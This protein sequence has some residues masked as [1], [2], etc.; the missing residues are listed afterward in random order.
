[1]IGVCPLFRKLA[2]KSVTHWSICLALILFVSHWR[3][4]DWS[5]R[6]T[7]CTSFPYLAGAVGLEGEIF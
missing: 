7:K 5:T 3:P 4:S 1:M 6:M 2:A